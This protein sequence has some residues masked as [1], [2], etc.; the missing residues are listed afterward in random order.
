MVNSAQSFQTYNTAVCGQLQTENQSDFSIA[1]H[2][3]LTEPACG[4]NSSN[5]NETSKA[6]HPYSGT[7]L[8]RIFH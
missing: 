2:I 1:I 4:I 6:A 8:N 7:A 5:A 3:G